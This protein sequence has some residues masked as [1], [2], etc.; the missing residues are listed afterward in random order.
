[1]R[2]HGVLLTGGLVALGLIATGVGA[3]FWGQPTASAWVVD[4][5]DQVITGAP[6]DKEVQVHFRIENTS[7]R[8][9]RIYGNT[10][11]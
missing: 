1:M 6:A 7:A 11:C 10:A 8:T 2:R 9:L 3:Y 5:P 4:R